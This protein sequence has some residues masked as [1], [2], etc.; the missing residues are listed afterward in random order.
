MALRLLDTDHISLALRGNFKITDRLKSLNRTEW[1]V[2]VVS[3]Q[4]IFN[5]WIV[6]LNDPRYREQ[7]VEL[8]TRL[9]QS[10]E[11]FQPAQVLNFDAAANDVYNQLLKAYPELGKRRL[12]K[13]VKI[14]A[15]ALANRAT[16]VTRNQKDFSLVP[17]LS[18]ENW[19]D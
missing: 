6:S 2:S 17:G 9:W 8:Y 7:Q 13:D 10:N 3:I 11:F 1:A 19:A 4:E 15:I 14:A 12:E 18:I 16:I 5:G